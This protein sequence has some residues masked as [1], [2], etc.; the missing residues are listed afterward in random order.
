A[1]R[2]VK[3]C[4][5][6]G[7]IGLEDLSVVAAGVLYAGG[8]AIAGRLVAPWDPDR[9]NLPL[10]RATAAAGRWDDQA[11]FQ[12]CGV[13]RSVVTIRPVTGLGVEPASRDPLA[14][15]HSRVD[16]VGSTARWI[17]LFG[18]AFE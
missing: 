7:Y 14:A 5:P 3:L 9:S 4:Q 2:I 6:G 15:V 11:E 17:E 18:V 10:A 16:V 12:R 8:R 1:L 13:V